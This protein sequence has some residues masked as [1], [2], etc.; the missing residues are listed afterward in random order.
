MTFSLG[1]PSLALL[2]ALILASVGLWVTLP[3]IG[4]SRWL[5]VLPLVPIVAFVVAAVWLL[6]LSPW[7]G[8]QT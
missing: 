8:D 6:A 4:I 2:A 7:S 5:A 3:R 1:L